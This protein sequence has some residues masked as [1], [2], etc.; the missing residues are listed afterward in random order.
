M[1]TYN[2]EVLIV[3]CLQ[4]VLTLQNITSLCSEIDVRRGEI[5]I[6]SCFQK[7][8]KLNRPRSI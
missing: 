6:A 8:V 1:M 5:A 4:V 7:C 2:A 3:V